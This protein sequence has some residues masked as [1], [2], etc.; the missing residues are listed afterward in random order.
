MTDSGIL[1]RRQTARLLGV[2]ASRREG[3]LLLYPDK[4]A[5]V[6]SQVIRWATSV[7]FVAVAVPS[8][9]LP[10]HIGPG[11]LVS[12]ERGSFTGLAARE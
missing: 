2:K 3:T 8:F 9:A 12:R 7:G 6:H 10:P 1:I 5:H 4:L 11:A